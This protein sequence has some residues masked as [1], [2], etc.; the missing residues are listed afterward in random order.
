M[1]KKNTHRKLYIFF[2]SCLAASISLGKFP[3]SLFLIGLFL[4]WVLELDFKLKWER[5]KTHNYLPIIFAGLFLIELFWLPLS[6]DLMTGLNV[7]RIK[8][9]LLLLP[10]IIGT[11][12]QFSKKESKIIVTTFFLGIIIS[13]I[14]VYLVDLGLLNTKKN[15]GTV[16][17]ISIFMSHIRYSILLSFSAILILFLVIKKKG[18]TLGLILFFPWIIFII[19]KLA[20]ITAILGLLLATFSM[21]ISELVIFKKRIKQI[22][23]L[24]PLV[25]FIVFGFYVVLIVKDYFH[26]NSY[27]RANQT[28]SLGGEEYFHNLQDNTTENG[29]FIWENIAKKELK[30]AWKKRSKTPFEGKDKKGQTLKKTLLRYLTSKGLKKDREGLM[31]LTEKEINLIENGRTTSKEYSNL[32]IRIRSLLH[33]SVA[34][35]KNTNPNNQTVTQRLLFWKTGLEI[36]L[37]KPLFGYGPGGAKLKYNNYYQTQETPLLEANQL[38]AHN[39]FLT[40]L[41]NVGILG[42]IIWIT[43]IF[44]VFT[45]IKKELISIFIPYLV[46]M[47]LSFL[48]DDMIEVQAGVT[49]FSLIGTIMLFS[50]STFTTEKKS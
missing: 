31:T 8:L 43:I 20:T 30:L 50:D 28:H 18:I 49:I 21:V 23:I 36:F 5:I 25:F 42:F 17:D 37:K 19:F 35:S 1:L 10:I 6:S 4:N 24:I 41:I 13:T 27:E 34:Y 16:R 45:Q 15:S 29:F 3:M 40:Q 33:E 22:Y 32:Q 12:G 46:L 26:V 11:S 14:L 47:F 9:P 2:I 7:L 48:S 44:Y 38:L 39:Q